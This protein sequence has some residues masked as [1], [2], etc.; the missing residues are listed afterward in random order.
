MSWKTGDFGL[1][2]EHPPLAKVLAAVPL[3]TMDLNVPPL[4]GPSSSMKH[5]SM[6]ESLSSAMTPTSYSSARVWPPP[7]SLYC[8]R[9]WYSLRRARCS[10][11]QPDW[12]AHVA[13]VRSQPTGA[14][15]ARNHRRWTAVLT[16]RRRLCVLPIWEAAESIAA[17]VGRS[18]DRPCLC[19]QA[20]WISAAP[21]IALLA[22]LE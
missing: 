6:A 2:P 18:W 14:R 8:G 5:F 15:S 1:N 7:C 10:E 19:R 16:V 20:H 3:L 11:P 12:F 9:C 17:C 21:A 22:L 4:Q 13:G